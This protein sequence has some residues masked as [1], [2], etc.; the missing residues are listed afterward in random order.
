M[1]L[2]FDASEFENRRARLLAKMASDKLDAIL[3]FAQES[4]FWLTGYD[5]FGYCFFQC[6]AVKSD[7]TMVLLTRSADMLQAKR[8]SNI[9]TIQIWVDRLNGDPTVDLKN[10]L[11]EM[12]LLG[13]KI[14]VEYDTHGL[15]GKNA[16]L[17][18]QQLTNFCKMQDAS[19]V[20][21][22][23]RLIKSDAEINYIR[24]AARLSDLAFETVLPMIKPG[25]DEGAILAAMQGAVFEAGGDYAANEFIIGSGPDALLCRYKSGRRNLSDEDQLTLEWSGAVAHYHA[26]MMRTLILGQP[27]FRHRELFKAASESLLAVEEILKPGTSFGEVFDL[28]RSIMEERG[29][30]KHRLNTNGYSIGARF[31]PSWMENQMFYSGNPVLLEANMSVF[32]HAM[33]MDS[34]SDTAMLLGQSFLITENGC[35]YLSAHRPELIVI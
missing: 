35:E 29:L 7:G 20:V 6:L 17:L 1:A 15:T 16:R 21:S 23:L 22:D 30:T 31:S 28:H 13:A 2:L 9:E 25:A 34:E 10:L 33:L 12:D 27:S 32:V 26:P 19:D 8:T 3:L 11:D 18:D 4:M 24:H 5:T 14:G